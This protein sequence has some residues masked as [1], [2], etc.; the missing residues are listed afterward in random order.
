MTI[1]FQTDINAALYA[2]SIAADAAYQSPGTYGIPA[3]G[4]EGAVT[5]VT[6][7][8][9]GS[10]FTG[11]PT[12]AFSGSGGA[13]AYARLTGTTVA[14]ISVGSAGTGYT[15]I[16]TV[17][18]TADPLGAG[19][20]ATATAKMKALTTSVAT[21]QS[22]TGSY[23]P[24]NTITLTGG[25]FSQAAILAVTTT[26]VV[27]ATVAAGGTGGS[28]GT[29]TVTGTTGTGTKFTASVTVAGG[30]ITAV[31]SITLGGSYTVNP[32]SLTNEPVTGASLSGAQL[33]VKMGVDTYTISN[34]GSYSV[35]PTNPVAQGSTNGS[36]TGATFNIDT[37]GVDSFTIGA[38]G[39]GYTRV[40]TVAVTGG[41]GAGATG[42]AVLTAT[43]V[44]SVVVTAGGHYASA[45]TVTISG[46]GGT[47]ATATAA[48]GNDEEKK[49][50]TL[51]EVIASYFRGAGVV[52]EAYAARDIIVAMMG[53]YKGGAGTFDASATATRM[54]KAGVQRYINQKRSDF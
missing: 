9:P 32:T 37:W 18:I 12:V 46:A 22:S 27:S 41:A 16:P 35:L 48:V 19:S 29:Q 54:V 8:G 40:P 30:A 25:T 42:T 38:A 14:S 17:T 49:L 36:G 7:T 43:T 10:G 34:A 47:G 4:V 20:S 39:S 44:A 26:K 15:S 45:P 5:G 33:N 28:A 52:G 3:T 24:G 51:I 23:A 53:T 21:P 2:G 50:L 31:L 6:V 13:A 11:N 1:N